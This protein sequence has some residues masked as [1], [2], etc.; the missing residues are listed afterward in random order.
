M[1]FSGKDDGDLV[2]LE[3][4]FAFSLHKESMDLGGITTFKTSEFLSQHGVEG[5]GDHG[6]K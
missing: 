5:I 4:Y 6:H 3:S 1:C 2:P